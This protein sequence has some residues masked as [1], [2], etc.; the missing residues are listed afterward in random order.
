VEHGSLKVRPVFL[1]EGQEIL[2]ECWPFLRERPAMKT[3]GDSYVKQ[4]RS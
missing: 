2:K 1:K 4:K 3:K